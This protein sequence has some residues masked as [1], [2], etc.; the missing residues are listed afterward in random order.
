MIDFKLNE[1]RCIKCGKCIADCP[2]KCMVMEEGSFPSITDE[3]KCKRCQHCL[4]VCPTAAISILGADPDLSMDLEHELPTAHSME[5]LIK[6]R[7]SIRKYKSKALSTEKIKKMLEI[8]WH[9]PTGTNAQG[10]L[11]TATMTSEATEDLRRMTYSRLGEVVAEM[12]PEKNDLVSTYMR[13]SHKAYTEHGLDIIFKDAPHIL[14]ASAPKDIPLPK[15]DCII[16]LTSFELLA[17][18]MGVGTVWNGIFTWCLEEV[19]P[20]LTRKLGIPENHALGYCMTFGAPA[21]KYQRTVQ[22]TPGEMNLLS[23]LK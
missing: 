10:V 14:I 9:A 5:T 16:A 12:D 6:G 11:F 22:R 15:E 20:E 13:N 1:E 8:S 19:L 23:S 17:Q 4:A 7:R 21:V 18:S 2:P 3:A